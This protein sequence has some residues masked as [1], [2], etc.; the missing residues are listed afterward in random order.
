MKRFLL[1]LLLS[2]SACA[3]VFYTQNVGTNLVL[4]PEVASAT[5]LGNA[6]SSIDTLVGNI[7]NSYVVVDGNVLSFSNIQD[8]IWPTYTGSFGS[9]YRITSV[10]SEGWILYQDDPITTWVAHGQFGTL[11]PTGP[12]INSDNTNDI[13]YLEFG[14]FPSIT[15]LPSPLNIESIA[16]TNINVG[17]GAITANGT[18]VVPLIFSMQSPTNG[19]T[20][21]AADARYL[22]PNADIIVWNKSGGISQVI[23]NMETLGTLRMTNSIAWQMRPI[24]MTNGFVIRGVESEYDGNG[25][26]FDINRNS[27]VFGQA[28]FFSVVGCTNISIRNVKVNATAGFGWNATTGT[29]PK[30][31]CL[32][33][34]LGSNYVVESSTFQMEV[35]ATSTTNVTDFVKGFVDVT[36]VGSNKLIRNCDFVMINTNAGDNTTNMTFAATHGG[37]SIPIVNFSNCRFVTSTRNMLTLWHTPV[38]ANF[39]ECYVNMYLGTNH[40]S[41]N[42]GNYDSYFKA[43]DS[44]AAKSSVIAGKA[45]YFST[46]I[47]ADRVNQHQNNPTVA[48]INDLSI[49]WKQLNAPQ[50]AFSSASAT[51]VLAANTWLYWT[52]ATNSNSGL[53]MP[54]S[55]IVPTNGVITFATTMEFPAGNDGSNAV[56]QIQHYVVCMNTNGPFGTSFSQLSAVVSVTNTSATNR[57]ITFTNKVSSV[58]NQVTTVKIQRGTTPGADSGVTNVTLKY[59]GTRYKV[60]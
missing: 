34:S 18:N 53:A 3:Q 26:L 48:E 58:S 14:N 35:N 50:G 55:E 49:G 1:F 19:I 11:P 41:G 25:F 20:Q 10:T 7:S 32:E 57:V 4:M 6:E 46:W 56:Y 30:P 51:P 5:A 43:L 16:C 59:A 8:G 44:I 37:A 38:G 17:A 12:Y 36:C 23:T 42:Y 39:S 45:N 54:L 24:S 52:I 47:G 40:L 33:F 60:N 22:H 2:Y 27:L 15:V 29:N 9:T 31:Y 21:A 13:K 28:G